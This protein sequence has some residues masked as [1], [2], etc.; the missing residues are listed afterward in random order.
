LPNGKAS[1]PSL[2]T[3]RHATRFHCPW[4][5]IIVLPLRILRAFFGTFKN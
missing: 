5:R 2:V 3:R 4:M 1:E